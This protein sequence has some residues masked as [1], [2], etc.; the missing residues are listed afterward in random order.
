MKSFLFG[1]QLTRE[2]RAAMSIH[3]A[4]RMRPRDVGANKKM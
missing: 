4:E 2:F 1:F 3:P